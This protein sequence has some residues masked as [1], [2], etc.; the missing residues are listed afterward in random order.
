MTLREFFNKSLIGK[1]VYLR[2]TVVGYFKNS[3]KYYSFYTY[4]DKKGLD[5]DYFKDAPN[6]ILDYEV[7][8]FGFVKDML[9]IDVI[10]WID[11]FE[12]ES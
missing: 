3:K 1:D 8:R 10:E 2:V 7:D 4:Y 11:D 12:E 5:I 6:N 9:S